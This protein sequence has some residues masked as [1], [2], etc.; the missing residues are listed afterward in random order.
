M[1]YEKIDEWN[2]RILMSEIWE[3]G[4]MKYENINEWNIRI[5]MSEI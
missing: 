4:W 2:L 5:L 1:K 3:H